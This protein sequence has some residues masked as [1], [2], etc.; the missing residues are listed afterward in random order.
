MGMMLVRRRQ[1]TEETVAE[2]R[3]A[4]PVD[5][6]VKPAKVKKKEN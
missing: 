5:A 4:K 6:E 2:K 1:P 3:P